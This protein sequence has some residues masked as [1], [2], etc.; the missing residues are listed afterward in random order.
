M[1]FRSF[2]VD[3]KAYF[4]YGK[5][6]KIDLTEFKKTTG[7]L[8]K[9]KEFEEKLIRDSKQPWFVFKRYASYLGWSWF[10]RKVT[11]FLYQISQTINSLRNFVFKYLL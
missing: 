9:R 8:A 11:N 6:D 5:L 4:V 3:F 2:W 7:H 10:W 1:L